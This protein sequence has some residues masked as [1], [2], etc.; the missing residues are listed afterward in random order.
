MEVKKS[1]NI[2]IRWCQ[3][4]A[5]RDVEILTK[6]VSEIEKSIVEDLAI[7]TG[8]EYGRAERVIVAQA[9]D[10]QKKTLRVLKRIPFF[11]ESRRYM[12]NREMEIQKN[13]ERREVMNETISLNFKE[14][15][16]CEPAD[17]IMCHNL[18]ELPFGGPVDEQ[19]PMDQ[20]YTQ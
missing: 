16:F 7:E 18:K 20:D 17:E 10:L 13:V 6:L 9:I 19:E 5:E 15:P 3:C 4:R 8:G 12:I 14:L 2:C 11:R 1:D